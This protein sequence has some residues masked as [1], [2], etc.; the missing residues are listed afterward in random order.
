MMCRSDLAVVPKIVLRMQT[1]FKHIY[2]SDALD[3]FG[4]GGMT[5]VRRVSHRKNVYTSKY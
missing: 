4:S 1:L 3:T 5:T 2:M